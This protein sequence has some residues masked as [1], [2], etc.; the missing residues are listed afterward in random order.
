MIKRKR[1]IAKAV[2]WR[3]I[4][5]LDTVLIGWIIS[6]DLIVG[7]SI[8]VFELVTKTVLYYLHERVWYKFN[9]GVEKK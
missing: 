6:G 8:G 9:Y 3:V 5:T 1:H 2:T 7:A 4:G